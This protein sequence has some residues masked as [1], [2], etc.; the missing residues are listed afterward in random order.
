[1]SNSLWVAPFGND[2][3][4]GASSSF[5]GG[6]TGPL[7]TIKAAIDKAIQLPGQSTIFLRGGDYYLSDAAQINGSRQGLSIQASPGE[8]PIIRGGVDLSDADWQERGGGVFSTFLTADQRSSG[9]EGL[10]I[11][12]EMQTAA[13]FPNSVPNVAESGWLFAAPGTGGHSQIRFNSGDLP[14]FSNPSDLKVMVLDGVQWTSNTVTV[15]G[16]STS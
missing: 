14:R 16:I 3:W 4:S 12:G 13:R 7:A 11:S 15:N 9:I 2:S 6:S 1:M 10:H 5:T 8:H